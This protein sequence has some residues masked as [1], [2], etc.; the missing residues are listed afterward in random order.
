M[1]TW[2]REAPD[3]SLLSSLIPFPGIHWDVEADRRG[4]CSQGT[5]SPVWGIVDRQIDFK[6]LYDSCA[7][8]CSVNVVINNKASRT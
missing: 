3:F 4:P 8:E 1:F 6:Y 7:S 2:G 5:Y